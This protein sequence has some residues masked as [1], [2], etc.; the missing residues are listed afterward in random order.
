MVNKADLGDYLTTN[1]EFNANVTITIG[2]TSVYTLANSTVLR[3]RDTLSDVFV[4]ATNFTG[5]SNN[6]LYVGSVTAA[7]VLSNAQL[8]ANLAN[9]EELVDI[10]AG[11]KMLFWQTTAP[12]NWTKDTTHNDKTIRVV[13]GTVGTGGSVAFSTLFGR[14]STD[15]FT[16]SSTYMPSMT[17]SH[18]LTTDNHRHSYTTRSTTNIFT[19]SGSV[20]YWRNLNAGYTGYSQ[21]S[22][23]GSVTFTG[24]G[25]AHNHGIDMRLQYVDIIICTRN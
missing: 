6:T 4:N 24:S 21:P 23:S 7:N 8:Q 11:T 3:V 10:P 5:T 15:N 13:S 25:T 16:I 1:N 2:N 12:L 18:S 19:S 17:M 14:T 9:L 20:N 22:V